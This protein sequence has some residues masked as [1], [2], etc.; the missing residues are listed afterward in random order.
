MPFDGIKN[1]CKIS[2]IIIRNKS[3]DTKFDALSCQ[4]GFL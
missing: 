2:K 1:D 4:V 3:H